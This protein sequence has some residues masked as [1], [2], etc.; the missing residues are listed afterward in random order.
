MATT[1]PLTPEAEELMALLYEKNKYHTLVQNEMDVLLQDCLTKVK[2]SIH[3]YEQKCKPMLEDRKPVPYYVRQKKKSLLLEE[4]HKNHVDEEEVKDDRL[5]QQ[6]A[7]QTR[8]VTTT[9]FVDEVRT[10]VEDLLKDYDCRDDP[11]L[12][13]RGLD[14]DIDTPE[15]V[16]SIL[17]MYPEVLMETPGFFR[18]ETLKSILFISGVAAL[19][20]ELCDHL[21]VDDRAGLLSKNCLREVRDGDSPEY[22]WVALQT[23]ISCPGYRTLDR[24]LIKKQEL[25]KE[26]DGPEEDSVFKRTKRSIYED[27]WR[28]APIAEDRCLTVMRRI[29]EMGLIQSDDF[30]IDDMINGP[31]ST[32]SNKMFRFLIDWDPYCLTRIR[33]D[34]RVALH[35]VPEYFPATQ[36]EKLKRFQLIFEL[37]LRY[38]PIKTG[39]SL[40]F[41][42]DN[43][44]RTPFELAYKYFGRK[45][46]MEAIDEV[47]STRFKNEQA[48]DAVEA[49]VH[50]ATDEWIDKQCVD[51][52]LRRDPA[53]VI[54]FLLNRMRA[55]ETQEGGV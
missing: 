14:S 40:L 39:I 46:T 28:K 48:Y 27:L 25:E 9:I 52:I 13:Y 45:A 33:H 49:F 17:R 22:R 3:L 35:N 30:A 55:N 6:E 8:R 24:I 23:I 16:D 20:A 15:E 38:F 2:E 12:G 26:E 50:A 19:R 10:V 42:Y 7:R 1:T 21:P 34:G 54:K 41:Q 11:L 4:L 47:L 44:D 32:L 36:T 51:F 53:T 5:V 37:G 43:N 29:K 31:F 18:C